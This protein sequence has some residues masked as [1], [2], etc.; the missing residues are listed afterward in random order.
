MGSISTAATVELKKSWP[1]RDQLEPSQRATLGA[2]S[3]PARLKRPTT[4]K[5]PFGAKSISQISEPTDVPGGDPN[6]SKVLVMGSQTAILLTTTSL[7]AV[8]SPA[9]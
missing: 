7:Q 2:N 5:S 9:M 6:G 3:L 4:I 1:I 8:N